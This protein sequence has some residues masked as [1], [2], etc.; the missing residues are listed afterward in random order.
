MYDRAATTDLLQWCLAQRGNFAVVCFVPA[1]KNFSWNYLLKGMQL[2]TQ[3]PKGSLIGFQP[4]GKH[5]KTECNIN[6]WLFAEQRENVAACASICSAALAA[7]IPRTSHKM[8]VKVSVSGAPAVALIDTG[9]EAGPYLSEAYAALH[10]IPVSTGPAAASVTGVQG[11]TGNVIGHCVVRLK[12]GHVHQSVRCTVIPMVDAF[13]L[14]LSDTWLREH[15]ALLDYGA[16]TCTFLHK[17]KLCLLRAVAS[18]CMVQ[19]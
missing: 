8:Q 2:L 13:D 16:K 11:A 1:G 17:G 9:A 19:I 4:D 5:V 10:G 14:L 15:K 6:V 3:L 7:V 12:L 18:R